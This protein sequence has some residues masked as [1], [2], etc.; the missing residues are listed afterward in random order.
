MKLSSYS[1]DDQTFPVCSQYADQYNQ[2]VAAGRKKMRQ[3]KVVIAG[4]ARNNASQLQVNSRRIEATG[5]MFADYKVVIYENDSSDGTPDLLKSWSASNHRVHALVEHRGD[6]VNQPVRCLQRAHRMAF[7]RQQCQKYVVEKFPNFDA[8]ILIDTDV[9]G[10]WCLDG[11]ANTFG[12]T[13]WDFV[14]SN[15]MIYKRTG[16]KPN[17]RIQYDAW[18]YREDANFTPLETQY[19]NRLQFQRGEPLVPLY[20]CF[21]GLGIYRMPAFKVGVYD[22]DDIEHVGFHRSLRD[23]GFD[24]IFLNPSQIV[25]Y[26]RKHRKMDPIV[27]KFLY[28]MQTAGLLPNSAWQFPKDGL[29]NR[30]AARIASEL[31]LATSNP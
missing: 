10:G 5:A 22:C 12:Q 31:C 17:V 23:N 9:E 4:L 8:V 20:S 28:G 25:L 14:G 21:G 24:Q 19:V 7:Y 1:I 11:I 2:A 15:G 13:R 18:A 26:G 6:P 27:S 16:L 30:S 29:G 3:M